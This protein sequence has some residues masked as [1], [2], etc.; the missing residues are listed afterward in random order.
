MLPTAADFTSGRV[1]TLGWQLLDWGSANLGQPDGAYRGEPWRYTS[2]Q[3]LFVLR[4]YAVDA[5]GR[6]LFRRAVLERVKG[7]GKSPLLAA[8][9]CTE[10]LGPT[11]FDGW[12][13]YGEP[14]GAPAYSP[15]VQIAAISDSQADNTMIL[16]GEMLAEGEAG[17]T[18]GIDILLSKVTAPGQR[19]IEKVTASPRGREGNRATF[20]VMDETHLWVPA[21]QGPDLADALRRNAAKMNAR[22]IETTNA[23]APGQGSVAEMSYNAFLKMQAGETYDQGIL[24]DTREVFVDDI[25]D[26]DKVFPALEEAYGD[27]AIARGGWVDLERIYAEIMDPNTREHVARRFYLNQKVEGHSTWLKESEVQGCFDSSLRLRPNREKFALGFKGQIRNGATALVSVRLTDFAVIPIRCWEKPE[28]A[29]QDWEVPYAEVDTVVRK[30]LEKDGCTKLVADPDNWQEIVG[31]WYGDYPDVVEELWFTKNKAKGTKAIER[32][33]TTVQTR[34]LR[35]CDGELKR[36]ILNCHT[37]EV[38]SGDPTKPAYIIRKESPNSKRYI[39]LAQAAVIALEAA[40]LSI[41]EGALNEVE[42][43]MYGVSY[44]DADDNEDDPNSILAGPGVWRL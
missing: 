3:A 42:H 12:D 17:N 2:E 1:K 44:E 34:R 31:R 21:E 39:T 14:V 27:A 10:M 35:L 37:E 13:A 24:F 19:K 15:L 26:R 6:W 5:A 29:P 7:W 32:F 22:T 23:H 28:K 16:V 33:E 18:P 38:T 43:E 4:F 40:E 8:V 41:E 11:R 20:I 30:W 36:H 25:Y 9:C